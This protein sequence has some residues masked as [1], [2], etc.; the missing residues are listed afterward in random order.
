M[1]IYMRLFQSNVSS[2]NNKSPVC[3]ATS[4]NLKQWKNSDQNNE[5]V[6]AGLDSSILSPFL[7]EAEKN[8]S[9]TNRDLSP[10]DPVTL[11]PYSEKY[12]QELVKALGLDTDDYAHVTPDIVDKFKQLLR[13]YPYRILSPRS[14]FKYD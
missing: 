9:H 8:L 12:F 14:T 6:N 5:M 11:D 7:M 2:A 3:N 13:M 1:C 4:H 10:T